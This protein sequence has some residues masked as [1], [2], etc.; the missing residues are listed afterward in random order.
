[1]RKPEQAGQCR[2]IPVTR[3]LKESPPSRDSTIESPTRLITVLASAAK[4]SGCPL[5]S[6]RAVQVVPSSV[7]RKICPSTDAPYS[8]RS[9]QAKNASSAGEAIGVNV[10]PASAL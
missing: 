4:D 6:P 5:I 2:A 10:R 3:G 7:E 8:P 1:M 9:V